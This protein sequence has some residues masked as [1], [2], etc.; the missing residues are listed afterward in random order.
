MLSP[1][2]FL[3]TIS[4]LVLCLILKAGF[5]QNTEGD[6]P[7]TYSTLT[8]GVKH[9]FVISNPSTDEGEIQLIAG[10][11]QHLKDI[12]FE[13]VEAGYSLGKQIASLDTYCDVVFVTPSWRLEKKVF[14]NFQI[15]LRS[16]TGKSLVLKSE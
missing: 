1:M 15:E 14:R 2:R 3:S 8:D 4:S 7:I 11:V 5:S 9:A 13:R 10:L 6:V 12:G 16:C